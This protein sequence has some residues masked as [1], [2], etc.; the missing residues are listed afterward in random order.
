VEFFCVVLVLGI[1]G[2]F[3]WQFIETRNAIATT[4]ILSNHDAQ[5]T[6]QIIGNAFTGARAMLWTDASGPGT[7][8]KRR[9]GVRGGITMSIAIEPRPAGG[10]RVRMWASETNVYV[11]VLVNFAGVVNRRKKAMPSC[12]APDDPNDGLHRKAYGPFA[13]SSLLLIK[14]TIG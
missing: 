7:I 9:R 5:R 10:A 11:G 2:F 3:V 1:I 14:P 4:E 13:R 6:A 12:S 8:N